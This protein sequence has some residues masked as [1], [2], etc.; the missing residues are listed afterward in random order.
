MLNQ[1]TLIGKIVEDAKLKTSMDGKTF[2]VFTL[3]ISSLLKVYETGEYKKDLIDIIL[4]RKTAEDGV[5]YLRKGNMVVVRGKVRNRTIV[6]ID[7][8][9]MRAVEVIGH[10]VRTL[11]I[12]DRVNY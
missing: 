12:K 8:K 2:C 6:G 1:V 7:G 10:H 4:W 3:E 5:D 11:T 9:S